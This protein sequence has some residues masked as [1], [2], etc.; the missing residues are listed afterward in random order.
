MIQR[1]LLLA[2]LCLALGG[3]VLAAGGEH[4]HGHGHGAPAKLQLDAGK[5]WPT[6]AALRGAMADIRETM[7]ASLDDIHRQRLPAQQYAA[8]AGKVEQAV[9]RIVAECKLDARADAQL[10][11]VV[12]E[13]LAGAER[14]GGKV[15]GA[16]RQGGAVRVIGALDQ[17]ATYF[18]DPGFTPIRH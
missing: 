5:K 17:Y 6:D 7:A 10:H 13:L 16:S 15:K 4:A 9:G 8:L 18:D 11:I 1:H 14:M 12:A 3:P 2:A